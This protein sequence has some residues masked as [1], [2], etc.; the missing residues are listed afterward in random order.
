MKEIDE[1]RL[2]LKSLVSLPKVQSVP[3]GQDLLYYSEYQIH[4]NQNTKSKR[5]LSTGESSPYRGTALLIHG[6]PGS[7]LDWKYLAPLLVRQGFRV[8]APD[9]P[10]FGQSPFSVS[11][12]Q[13]LKKRADFL[14][15]LLNKLGVDRCH[16]VGHSFGGSSAWVFAAQNP[17]RVQSLTLV[18][19]VQT[20]KH[21]SLRLLPPR[22]MLLLSQLM[23]VPAFEKTWMKVL[24]R[25]YTM[26]GLKAQV[27]IRE[28]QKHAA[29]MGHLNF[30]HLKEAARMVQCPVRIFHSSDDPIIEMAVPYASLTELKSTEDYQLIHLPFGWHYL[31]KWGAFEIAAELGHLSDRHVSHI[32]P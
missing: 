20:S 14:G 1:R 2:Q 26:L 21:W 6:I 11:P 22:F 12:E 8:I 9:M 29:L 24:G 16:I 3:I 18:N 28:Y 13:S 25:G 7:H 32:L 17:K 5:L 30:A 10:G 31:Q 15:T 4:E 23:R 27:S 19:A